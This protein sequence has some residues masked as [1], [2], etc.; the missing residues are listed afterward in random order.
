LLAER[1]QLNRTKPKRNRT[2]LNQRMDRTTDGWTYGVVTEFTRCTRGRFAIVD[3]ATANAGSQLGQGIY[4]QAGRTYRMHILVDGRWYMEED[5][6]STAGNWQN[7]NFH[8]VMTAPQLSNA[9]LC[10]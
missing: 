7:V 3:T 4:R 9:R 8:M 5:S 1:S 2:E 10:I 6:S